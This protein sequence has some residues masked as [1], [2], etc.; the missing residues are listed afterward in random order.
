MS[1]IL[2]KLS[3]NPSTQLTMLSASSQ[4]Q[5]YNLLKRVMNKDEA[6]FKTLYQHYQPKILK[7][8]ALQL[9]GDLEHAADIADLVMFEVWNKAENYQPKAKVTTWIHSIARYKVIDF[10][11]KKRES[12]T[13][14]EEQI[15]EIVDETS[16]L[17][18]LKEQQ[19]QQDFLNYCIS[20][21]NASLKEVLTLIYLQGFSLKDVANILQCPENTVKTR[22]FRAREKLQ[23]CIQEQTRED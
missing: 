1:S 18:K 12:Q 23:Q 15:D 22:T 2:E 21:L 19:E 13:C 5:D 10:L 8:C 14:Y 20:A 9:N 6:A 16:E 7:F 11:R 3:T 17:D 4:H